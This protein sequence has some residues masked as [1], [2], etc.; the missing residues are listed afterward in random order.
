MPEKL[1]HKWERRHK[2]T[3]H[4]IG[5]AAEFRT[6]GF[7]VCPLAEAKGTRPVCYGSKIPGV[8]NATCLKY[9]SC[10]FYIQ[11]RPLPEGVNPLR[12]MVHTRTKTTQAGAQS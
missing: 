9:E 7:D 11:G 3:L 1:W 5:E 6:G 12:S 10:T 8:F 2:M 4:F